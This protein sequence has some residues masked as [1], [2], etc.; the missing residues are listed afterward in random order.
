[1]VVMALDHARDFLGL[2]AFNVTDLTKTTVPYF[3]TRWVTHCCAPGFMFLA[4]TAA[5]LA[6]RSRPELSPRRR[7]G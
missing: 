6:Q 3:L 5:F 4:G 2:K 1:M 7:S